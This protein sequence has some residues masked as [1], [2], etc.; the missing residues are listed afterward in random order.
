MA[1]ALLGPVLGGAATV[2]GTG[3]AFGAVAVASLGLAAWALLTPAS[4]PAKPQPLS[5][6]G[7]AL[8]DRR[9]LL[10]V[11]FVVLPA[12]LFGVLGVLGPLRLSDLG[13]G[14]SASAL[15]GSW[16][17]CSRRS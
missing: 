7:A 6:L 2:V 4:R 5:M 3:W 15:S 11:W 1:G 17:A 13:V 8:R 16:P 10:S 9:V 14:R 12:L